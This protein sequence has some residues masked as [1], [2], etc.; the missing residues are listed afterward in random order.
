MHVG[1]RDIAP[2]QAGLAQIDIKRIPDGKQAVRLAFGYDGRIM[3]LVR[4]HRLLEE[5]ARKWHQTPIAKMALPLFVAGD[6]GQEPEHP[7]TG[8][9]RIDKPVTEH[10]VSTA[11]AIDARAALCSR[12]HAILE[13]L[14]GGKLSGMQFRIAAGQIN[15]IGIGRRR[16]VREGR[17]EGYFRAAPPPAEQH[18]L[19]TEGES[20]I[21]RHSNALAER[22]Q[23]RNIRHGGADDMPMR[24]AQKQF[25]IARPRYGLG[26]RFD[27]LLQR[28]MLRRLHQPEMPLRQCQAGIAANDRDDG[29]PHRIQR[30]TQHRLV[31]VAGNAVEDNASDA[32]I[33]AKIGKT[34]DDGGNR[35]RHARA[36]DDKHDGKAEQGCKIGRRTRTI[37]SAVEE[38]HHP[39]DDKHPPAS[40]MKRGIGGNE[41]GAH[42]PGIEV[43]AGRSDRC[44]VEGGIDIVRS[45]LAGCDRNP[46]V[47]QRPQQTERERGLAR[48]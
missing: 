19:V 26:S 42:G 48:A 10:H 16:L 20:D 9:G 36:I 17:K 46:L 27:K 8:A 30:P 28:S 25:E 23:A 33:G 37:G 12:L 38:T 7:V 39:L 5:G 43:E 29:H 34:A 44:G 24:R 21:P 11:L 15:G 45:G 18:V 3:K 4:S 41:F 40:A 47:L 35:L 22:H 14:R 2:L 32:D 1:T 6:D 31:P 13:M